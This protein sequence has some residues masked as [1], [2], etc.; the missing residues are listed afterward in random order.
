MKKIAGIIAIILLVCLLTTSMAL[1][2]SRR[3]PPPAKACTV[4]INGKSFSI[5][6]ITTPRAVLLE[7]K[8]LGAAIKQPVKYGS[9]TIVTIGDKTFQR[10]LEQGGKRYI[11]AQG[12]AA[13]FGYSF[14]KS[15]STLVFTPSGSTTSTTTTTTTSSKS[16][17]VVDL[18]ISSRSQADTSKPGVVMLTLEVK[19]TNKG[20]KSVQFTNNNLL[21]EEESGQTHRVTRARFASEI[22]LKPGESKS[23]DRIYFTLSKDAKLKTLILK[24]S[25]IVLGKTSL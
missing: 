19:F 23:S 14:S 13:Q 10:S 5:L 2:Q 3:K 12:F 20:D 4:K 21:L 17:G 15:G 24:R 16:E 18:A 11:S 6:G 22:F 25:G 7:A 1:S 8:A 9:E